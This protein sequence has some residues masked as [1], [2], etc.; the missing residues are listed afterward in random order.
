MR[1]INFTNGGYGLDLKMKNNRL[2]FGTRRDLDHMVL[3][4]EWTEQ[5]YSV[6]E[7][8]ILFEFL[9]N[10]LDSQKEEDSDS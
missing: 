6:D 8:K 3:T 5:R 9:Q 10:W 7:I 4:D 2:K 1:K